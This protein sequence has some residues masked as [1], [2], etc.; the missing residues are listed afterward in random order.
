MSFAAIG[1]SFTDTFS[2]FTGTLG[3]FLKNGHPPPFFWGGGGGGRKPYSHTGGRSLNSHPVAANTGGTSTCRNAVSLSL[4]TNQSKTTLLLFFCVLSFLKF[5]SC[6]GSLNVYTPRLDGQRA[7]I[8]YIHG[9]AFIMGGGA[10]YFFGPSYL[11]DQVIFTSTPRERY[12]VRK[13][14]RCCGVRP[15]PLFETFMEPRNRFQGIKSASPCS[16]AC[17]YDNPI[18]TRFQAPI[19]CLKFPA[20]SWGVC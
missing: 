7:V 2:G 5:P 10:S 15:E 8:V 6:L 16:L 4:M 12:Y 11:M 13:G 17:R 18:P 3:P 14:W 9:G 1:L 19:D 20:Q